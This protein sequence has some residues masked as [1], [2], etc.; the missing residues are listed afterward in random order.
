MKERAVAMVPIVLLALL[1]ALTFW[2]NRM[3]LADTPRG[4]ERHDPDYIV[5][6][7]KVSRFDAEGK[8]QH[9]I[10]A[11]RMEH[12]PDDDTTVITKPHLTY[13]Q[14]PPTDVYAK[15]ALMSQNGKEINLVDD[16]RVVRQ[17]TGG[18]PPT[19]LETRVLKVFP[20]DEKGLTD[21]PVAISQGKSVIHGSGLAIDNKAGLT[22]LRG[23][24]TGTLYRNPSSSP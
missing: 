7:F 24:V 23:R 19:V 17:G 14:P 15:L 13:H 6:R 20:D 18:T 5:E 1:A 12:F 8:L 11:E 21:Q 3:I 16:V 10:V 22:V 2:L 4:P 9:T